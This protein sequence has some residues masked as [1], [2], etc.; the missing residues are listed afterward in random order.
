MKEIND[1]L[2]GY[3]RAK[4][5]NQQVALATVVKVDGSSYRRPGARMLVAEDGTLT[6][7][8]SGGCLE[9]DALKKAMI[10]MAQ[11]VNKLVVY[12]TLNDDDAKFGM[13]LGCNGR[14]YILFEPI[15]EGKPHALTLLQEAARTNARKKMMTCFSTENIKDEQTGTCAL[16]SESGELLYAT[17]ANL[18]NGQSVDDVMGAAFQK[19]ESNHVQLEDNKELWIEDLLPSISLV[20]FGAGNDVIPIVNLASQLGWEV[21]VLDGRPSHAVKSRFNHA[22]DVLLFQPDEGYALP[23]IPIHEQTAFILMSHNFQYD[24]KALGI[25][26]QRTAPSYIGCL[27]PKRRMEKMLSALKEQTIALSKAQL[28]NLYGPMGLDIG[29]ETA[30]EIALAVVAEIKAHFTNSKAGF[31]RNKIHAIHTRADEA[32][33]ANFNNSL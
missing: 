15:V 25:L 23:S 22:K 8:I 5:L 9:G 33:R 31:L 13:Q 32:R 29:A 30:E 20:I 21:T 2:I 16:F 27:G 12:D 18:S 1:I 19:S 14:V 26:S 7:A 11:G 3:E 10:A 17:N 28:Q 24:L 6:G 4:S